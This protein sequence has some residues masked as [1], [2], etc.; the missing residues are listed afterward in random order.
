MSKI[1]FSQRIKF[2]AFLFFSLLLTSNA[3]ADGTRQVMPN[4]TNGTAIYIRTDASNSGP[5]IGAPESN[6]LYFTI[7]DATSENLY[8]G[9]QARIRNSY[10]GGNNPLLTNFYYRIFNAAGV[11]QTPPTLFTNSGTAAGYIPNYARA[12]AGPNIGGATPAGYNPIVFDPSANGDYYIELYSS[13]D[14]GATAV[15]TAPGGINF[16]PYFDFTVS[17]A[18]NNQ[19]DGRIWSRKW[20][21]ITYLVENADNNAGTP[22]VPNPSGNASFEGDFFAYTDDQVIVEVQFEPGFR[23]FGYQ[24]AM[25]RFGVVNDDDN[26]ANDFLLTR[27]SV[28]YGTGLAPSLD[29]GFQI[30]ITS[31]DQNVFVPSIEPDPVVA[32]E[33]RGCPGN[34]FIPITL[35]LAQDTAIILDFN[36]V[37]GYQENTEDVLIEVYENTPGLKLIPWDGNDGLGNPVTGGTTTIT[38]TSYI[39]RTNVPMD[40]AEL[41]INGLSISGVAPTVGNRRLFWD[42][43][44]ITVTNDGTGCNPTG[45]NALNNLTTVNP[46]F[47]RERLIDGIFG[48]AHA[49]SSSNPDDSVPAISQGGNNTNNVLCDDFGNTRIVNTWFYGATKTIPPSPIL[50]PSCDSDEDGLTDSADL[51]DDNDGILDTTEQAGLNPFGDEDGDGAADYYDSD[52]SGF[53]DAN[54]DGISDQFDID[55]DGLIN[56]FD[57]DADGDGC[58]DAVEGNGGFVTADLNPDGSINDTEDANGVPNAASG[59]QNDVSSQNAAVSGCDTDGDGVLNES[60]ICEGFDD[61][62]DSD[63]DSI[64]DGCDLDDDNDGI[65]DE[66]ECSETLNVNFTYN[67]TLSSNGNLVFTAMINGVEEILT[68]RQST[69]PT[70]YFG[71]TNTVEPSGVIITAG[72]TPS[73]QAQ[74]GDGAPGLDVFESAITFYSSIAI[75]RIQLP[76]LDDYDRDNNGTDPTDGIA[77]TISG[78][79]QINNGDMAS[80]DLNTGALISNN[81][82]GNASLNLSVG[83]SSAQELVSR[84]AIGSVLVRGTAG[85][86]TNGASATFIA[87]NPFTNASLL[88]EDLAQNGSR[89]NI[90]NTITSI[91]L[92]ATVLACP[93]TDNDGIPNQLDTDS[94]ADGC[95]DALEGGDNIDLTSVDVNGQLT[96]AVNT[97][98]GVPNNVDVNNGQSVGGSVDGVPSDAFGQCDSDGDGVI[99]AN[100]VCNGYDDNLNADGDAVPDGC[101]L[102]DDNDGILDSVECESLLSQGGFENVSGLNNGNNFPVDIS[103]WVLG[104][105]NDANVVQ[106]DGAGGFDYGSAGPFEDANPLTGAGTLQHYLDIANGSNDFYQSFTLT[107]TSKV[108]YSGYFSARDNLVGNGSIQ[109]VSGI[110][111]TG[112]VMDGTGILVIDSNGDSQNTPWLFIEREV[113]LPPGTYSYVVS[114]EEELNF[115]EARVLSCK[116]TDGDGFFDYQDIDSDNDGCND[117]VEAGHLDNDNNGEVDGTS[118]DA[119][120][121]V[122]GYSSAYTGTNVNV[123]TPTQV[124]VDASALLDQNVESGNPATF[125]IT[126]VS[127]TS[128]N[129]YT[130][131]APNTTP[132]YSVG[133][134]VSPGIN[135]QWYIGNPTSGGTAILASD[136]NYTGENS[137]TLNILDV[138][139]LNNTQYCL[140]ITHDNNNCINEINCV[141]LTVFINP[142]TQDDTI[143]GLTTNTAAVVDPFADNGNGIDTDPDGTLDASTVNIIT[144]GATDSDG[145]GD[146]D[147]L[148]VAGEGTW[149]VDNTTGAVTFTP[150]VGFTGDPTP[151][152]YTVEDNDGNVSNASTISLDYDAQ[153][154]ITQD[155]TITGLTTN[156]AAVVDPFADNGNGIDTDPD[157]TLDASTVNIITAGA[158]DSDGD[159]DNDTLVVAGEGTWTVDNTTGAVTFTPEVGFTGDPTP[160]AYTVED[161]DGN[162]SNAS[163]ISLDYDAQTPITQDD[164]ITG[165][166]TNTAAVVDPFADNGNGIDTDPDGTLDAST[167]NIITA[168]ATD[169]DGDGDND[170]LVVAGEGTWTVDNTTGAVT[171]TPEVGF[172]G[173]P[174]PIAYTVEDN[175]GNVSNASTISLDYD[176]QTPITQDDTITGLTTNTAAVVDPFAD[177]GN[178]IDTDPDGTL[179]ASTVNIITAGA[180]D[181]DGD[182][183]NDTLV[184]AG[185]GTWTV[186]NTT[187]AV[188][189]T[190]EVGF[191]GDPTPI[192]YTVEDN[193]GNV[194][195]ASTISLDYDAQT[196]ITQD[197]TIT[198][199]TTNTA[200]VVDPFADNGNGIDT[201]PDG[202]LDA[203]TVNIIT[204]GATDSDGDG[205]NDT[206]VVAGEGTWT[207]DNTTGAVTFTPEVGFTGDP[208]PIAYTVEDN[209]GNVSNA[210]TISLDY[211]AQTPITQ[212][213][214]ITGL[215]TN[216]AAVV[217]PFA[218]NGN[219]IDTDPDGTLDASTVNIITAGATDSDGDGDNDTLVVAGEGTWTVDNTTGAVTFTPEVGFTGDPTPIAYTVEDND[220]NVSNASTISLDYDAQTPITQD[221]TITGLTT[222]TA[223]V[224]DPFADNGNGIDTDPDGTLDAS[225]VNI[226]TAGATDSDG[227]GDNDTLVVAGEG[228]WTVDNTT[229]AVTFTPEVGFTGDPTPI[230]YTVEDNDGN[231]SNAST[232][233][234]DYDAQTPITQDDTITGLTTNTAAV[235]DPFADNGNGIDTDPDG[236]LDASTVNIITAGATD[237]DGD[238]DNDTLVVAG[239]GTWTVDNTTGAVTFTPEVGFTGDPTPIAYTVEDNDGNVSNAST[240]SLDYDAQTPITQ[241]DTITGLTTN[242]AAVVDPFADNGNGIDTDPDGTLDASTVNI[243]T[244]GATDSDGDGDNDTLVVAGEGTWTVDN[245]TGAVTFTP[246]VG[247]TGDPT[248]IAYTVEDNDGNVSNASTISL[249]YDAQTPITQDDTITGLTTNTAAVVDPFADNGNGIDTDPD[250]TLDA[251]TVNIIT[252]GATDSDGDGDNDTLV[253]AGEGTWTVDN[254][255]GAVTFT[256]EVGFTGDPT[257]IAYTVED[258]D[259]NVSNASTISL[260]YDA[261]TPITQDDTITGLTTNTAAVVD[262]FADNG[263]GIDTD[264]DGTLDA[265][266]VNIITAG[267]TDSDGDGDNDTLVVAGEGTWTVDNTTGAV[268]FTPEVGFTGDP[269][270]IAYTVEDNDG[271]VSNASTISLDYDAQTP[272]T[273]DDTITGLTTN[274]AAV[275]DPFAD[276]GNGIDTDPDGTLDASTVN[277]ITAGAT[278]SDGD[279]DNDTLVVAGEGTW[280]VDNTTGAVTFTPEVG[281]TG[282]PTP[283]AYTVEDNDGN[284]SNAS[285]ISL[286]YDAQTPITQDDTITGLTTNTAAVVDPFADNG[287]GIDTD[288][289]GTLDASTVNIITAGATDSDGDGDNDT[290]VVAGE[291]TWTVDNTTG[292]VTFTP[293]VGF[294]GDPTPIAYTVE[295]NDGNVSNASTISLDYDAQTPITQDDTITGLTTNTAAVVD[296]FA[297][298]GNG[299]DTDPDGTLDAST[300][301]IITAG[302]TD[303]DGDGDNDTLVVAGEGTWTVDNTTGAVTFTPEVGFTGDPTPIAYTVED[304]DGNVSNASTISLD[305]D[306][307]TPITQDDTITGLTTN[308]AAVVDPFAD[309]GNG[310]DT[311]PDGTLDASTV[312]I[313]T[314]GATDSDGD[315]DNDTL[316]V[317]GEGTWTVDNTTGAVTFTPEVGFTGDPTPIAYTVEDNDGNVS[318]AS[319]ISLDYD[320]QTPI[321]QDDTITGL[322]TNT[323][324]VVDPFAD[325]GN[326]I[327]TDPDGTLDASTVN[328]ITAGAT[329][330]DGDGDNDTLVVAGEGTWTVDNTTGAV[331]FTP[332]VGFTGD[333]T[334]IAYTVEDNDGNVSNA[335]TISLD[336]DA[337]TPIT[338]DDT[339]TGLTTNTAAVVDP[340]AD[341]G[342]GIDTDPDGTLD[343][344][345]VNIITAGATDSDGDGDNDTLVV[346]GEGT[347]TVD[348]TTGAV[349]FTPEVGFT[350]D[351]TPIAYT[352]EDNDGNVSNASTISL[353]YDAQ[354]PI[355]QDDTITGL[356]TNTAAVV[357]PFADNGNGIDTDPDGTLDASTVNIITAGAT[358]SDGDGDNDTLVVAGEG[359]WTVDNTTGAVTFTPEVGFTGDPTPIAYTVEDNDGNVSNASTISLDYDAQTPIT[360]D[361]TITGLTTNTAAVVDPFADNGN[362]I[363]TDPDGTLDASTVNIITA[364]ATDSDGDGDNDTLVVAGEGTWTVDNTTGAVTFTPEVGFTGDPTPIAYTVEDN[365]GNVSNASTISL[366]YDAQT[367]ITQDDTITGLTTNTA[368]VVD[369][370]ADN[371]NGI[372]T[373][374]DGTLDASTVNIITA[375]ATDSDGDGD[376]DTLVVAGEGTWTVDNTTGAVTFTPEVGFT[377]D[378]TP[379]AYTVEDN[380]GNVSN[381]STI[382]LDYDAQTPITQDDTITGLTTNTAAVVDPFAD[383]GNGIDTD[384]DGTL[385]ASTVNIITAGATDSDGDGDN[386]T[387]V[388]AGEGTWTVDNTT[389]AVTFTPEVGFTGDPTPIA[390]TVEDNDGNVSN[391]STISLD[392]D[393]QTPITQD[394]TITGLTTNTAAVVDPFADNGNGIDTDPDG[395]LDASTV[396]IIT[397][398][399]TDSDGDGDNDTLVVAGEGTWT[400][401]NTTG[402]VTFT[403]E[404]GFTGDPTPI[405]YTVE[406]NDGNVSNASTISLDYDAQ[407]PITQ[408]DTI[409]GLTT[410]TAAVVDPFADNGNGIDTDPDGTLD[411]STVNIITAGATDSDGDGDNDTLVV[412]GE[413]TWTVDNTTGAVTFTPEVGF[414]G[415]P[416]PI[417]YTVEDNDGNVSN[418]STISL[419]YDAQTPITQDDTITG[420][421]TNTAAVVDPFADNGN[422]IDTDPDG[423]LD[424]STVNIITAGATDS[425]GDGDNDTLVVAGE[426]TWTVDNT[427]GAVTFTPE[428]GFTGDPTPIAY[429][430]EDNDGNVSN[431]STISLDYDAQT[432]ITQD[433]TITGLTTN[434]AAVVD[435]FA[436]N[437]NGIDTDP[438]GTL[439]AST[440]NIITAGATDSDG[441]GDN[442][443]LVVAGEGT[444]TVDNTTGAVTFTPE[445]GFT[446]DPTPIAYTVEDNDGNV[447]NASTISLDYDAQTPIAINDTASTEPGISIVI[448]ILNNDNDPDGTIE[449]TTVDLDPLTPGQ[450]STITVPGEGTYTDNGDGTITFTPDPTFTGTTT[451]ISYTVEDNDGN[452]SNTAT[453]TVTVDTCPFPTDSDGD[454]LTDCEETTG[455]D[456]PNT[457]LVPTGPSDPNDPCDPIGLDATDTDGDGLTDCEETTGNDDPNTP[458]VPTGPS[459]PND[460]CDPIG[461]DATDTDGDGLTDCE[462]TTGNDDPNTPLVPTGP[463]DPNDPCDPIGLDATDTDGDG[464]TDCEETTGND[465]PNT[466]LVP[467]GPSDPNDPCDPIGLNATDTDGD[468]LTD[469]EE[470]TGNDDPNTP[471]VPTGPSDPNDPCDPIGLDATDTDGD[472]LTDCEETTGN[473][474]PNTPLVPTGPSDPNDPCDPIGLDATD[475]DGDGLTD[476][477]ETTGNDDP[478]TPLVPTGPSDPNDPCD[479]IGLDATDTDG[480][481]LT[482]CEE[483]TG[484]DDPNTPLV[485]TGPSD[486]NDPCDPIGLDATDTDGDGLTDCEETT[487]NDDP[488]TPLVPT[489]PSDPNDPCDPNT[490]AGG[491]TPIAVDDSSSTQPNTPVVIDITDNDSDPNGTIED[492]TV[493]LDPLTPGQQS[494]ITV[495]GEGTYTD[496]GDGTITFTPDPTFT[497]TTTPI[498]YT[499]EDNDGNVS[500]TATITVTVDTCPFPTDSDGDG[501]TDCEETT[502]NDDPNTPLVPT[503][504]SD[505]N[506]PCDPIG[507]D[508]TDTDGDGL[509]DCEETTGNDDPNTPLVP[510]GP[511]DPND[512]C[513]PIGLN[514]TDTDGDGLTDCEE[515]TGNDDPNTPLVPTGPSDP[516]DPCDPIG[517]DATDTD[518]DGLTDCEETTGNDDPNTPLVPTGPSDPNDP[519]DPIGLDAT[520]TDGDGLTDCEETTG[521]DDPNTPLVPTGPSDPNDPCDPIGLDATDTDGDGL[522]DCEET[523]GND[524]PNTPLVPTGPSDPNDPCD[525]IGLDATDTDGDG[526]T[527]CEE[528]T[529]NDDPNTPLVPTGPSDPNDPCDPI[530]LDATDTDGDGLTDCEETTGNDDP[531]TPLVPTGPSDPND[532]CDPIGLN[533][534][535]TDGDGLT[536]C[537][538]TTGNDDPNTPLVP[539]GPSDPND[540]CDPIGLDA[541]DTDGDGL[542]DCEETTGN[543]DPNTPLVPTG[544]SDPNDP[545]DP[546]G[547][548]ATD[549]DGDGLT[550][551]EE[552]TG[553]DDPNTP[554]VPTGPSDP[555][556]PCDP[557]GLDATDTD[558]DGLTDCEE[559]TG[560]DDPNTPLV[561]TGPS[562]PND[563]CD[564]IGLDATDTD[565]DG[566]TDCEETTGNDDPNTPLVPTGPSDPNDPCDPIGLNATDTDGD[567]LTDCEETTGNDD[568][569]TPLVPTGPSDPNDP[570]D[571][572]GLDATDTDGDG[573][574]DCEETTGNDDPN[575]PLVPTG[576]SDPNDPCDPIGLDATDTDGDGL[577][578]CEETTGNDD[579][580]TPLV[581]TGPSDPNDPCDPIGLDA[582]DTD[583]DGLTD[584]E[585]TTGNDDP[586]T[587]LVPTGPSDPNDPC[588]P[589]GLDA[590][591]TDGDGLTDCEETTGNDDPNTPLVP[592]GPSDPNDPC[593][594][595]TGAGGC[596][597]IAVD[598]SSST[599]P[600]TPVVIDI[601]DNDSDPNGTIEDTT[602]DLDPLTPGQQ[603]T[604]TVPGEGTYT[605]NGDGT[606]TFTP[607]PTFTGTTTPIS[608]TVEDN[609][610]NVSNTATITVTVDTCPFPTDSDGDGL[611]DCEETTGNDDPNT[612]LVPTG[613][614]D[615]N[616]P[617]DPIGLD[618]TDTDGDGLTDCEETTGNDD[619]NTPL[620][621]TGPSDP[622]DP[623]D[624][625]GLDATDT[626]GDGLTDCEETTGNDDPNTPLVPTGPSDPNDPC[627]PIGLDATDTD[628]DGLTDCEE[629]TGN[630]DPNTPLV[631]TGPSDPND[632]CDP[633]GLDATDTDGDGLTDC[634]ETTGN[635]DPNTPLVPTGPSDPNDPCDPNTGAGGCTPIAVDD[636]SSTQPNTPVVI[637]ITD[638]DSDPNGTIE[639]TTVDLDPL[640]PGQQSTITVPGEGTYTDNGDG[641]I[642][643]TPDPTF[644]G[645]TTPISYTVEDNDGNVSNT[646]TITVTVDTCPFPTDSDGDGLTDCEETTGNDD[647]NTPLV[648][649]GPSDPNDPCDPIGL[650]ATDTDGDGLTDCEETTGN[651]DPN[652]PLVPTGP[653]DPNDPCDPIG[654]DATDTD[655]D[656]LTDC[657]ETT[658]N[659]DPNTPLVPTGP[660][661]PN[662]PCD[663]IGLNATDTD[664]DGLTDCEETTGNDDPNTPLVPTG[665]S[666]PNDPCDPIGLDATDTD[667]DGLTDCEETTGND[668]PNTPLVPTGPSDPNDPCDPIGLDATDSDGDGLTDCEETTGIDDPNTPLVPTGPSDP[669]DPCDPN[670]GAGGCTPIAVDDSVVNATSGSPVSVDV[671]SNDSDANGTI[672]PT[673]VNLTDP[674]AFDADG[675]GY[676]DTLVVP[677]EG[678]WVVDPTT[679]IITFI[680]ESGFTDDPTPIGYTV[681]DNDGNVSNEATVSIDYATQNPIAEDDDS[682]LN[683]FGSI[684]II[685]LVA[686][687]GNGPDVDSDGTLD[688]STINITTNGATD[689]DGDGFNDTLV[690]PGEGTWTIDNLGILTFTPED[691]FNDNPTPINYTI[692]DNDGNVS[693]QA[694]I[695]ITYEP[696]GDPDGDGV[697]S[698]VEILEGT[699]S[700]NPCDYNPDSV[701]EIQSEPWLSSDCDGDGYL[702]E[703][704]INDGTNPLDACDFNYLNEADVAQSGDWFDADCD[705]DNVPNGVEFPYG[706]TD[707]DGIPDWLDPDDDGDGIDTVN[708]DYGDT[709]ISDGSV[710]STGDNNPTNDDTDGDGIPDYLD[711]DDDND[712]ILTEDEYPDSNGNGIGFGDDAVDSDGDGLPDYLGVNNANPSE[713][714]LEVFNAVTPNGD[715]DN[716]VFVI[717]NIELYPDNTVTIYNRWGVIVYQTSGYG[718]SGNFFNGVSNGRATIE[719]DKQLPVGTYF[720]II[721]YNNGNE[722]K[723]KAGYLY[724]QR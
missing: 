57:T 517:L 45:S 592:T 584:C 397:A 589:I 698:S 242:T 185:E 452:V 350:G 442:D 564:P 573:L 659:D 201:D 554:L 146:N 629:T 109:I 480:D 25:N 34:Y 663:P 116:D 638:N 594:P 458:L 453:I 606:I 381:A 392:Y 546:I 472:G 493:D 558:G 17:D 27:G 627:D 195:N 237:S 539:T 654:L 108:T 235:V 344:S 505:P 168:G 499:V 21:F 671:T 281:F 405:A 64:P 107:T 603:S 69:N 429:T 568:P 282:D 208:T 703:T 61:S 94:D 396:N 632:P 179:D 297:D 175:D 623:C 193:D 299:I 319:T 385:D 431:A 470:T 679:G 547:L 151:I 626:D 651:D 618:A 8:F 267:A 277:I 607:D 708:E 232:I 610:G 524:D 19:V 24:L 486:P 415:D 197:D 96:G 62:V 128:T 6:R 54:G 74:D 346:A 387:L 677:G 246:E 621:P 170:T 191:T 409:T 481:G 48:P 53:V 217:D 338:Q 530:G 41:N 596:T 325:N 697:L 630:D 655:G 701:T 581:P 475:T 616:D 134:D 104:T 635:D 571:P 510:T 333:P 430:V 490:G 221:D 308:T 706:D 46:A 270:P 401:D 433:D 647:P 373:D 335:S 209:D 538:E 238:G 509:T 105:G 141:T 247:F 315:G 7:A 206:L 678:T 234:L 450:Q 293:E 3:F 445:V 260:D 549:T 142:I 482:D 374:P 44:N 529:G 709:D 115:D 446:G 537:E 570:C 382:S 167:V 272:I 468:G 425:D 460:P 26:P 377:G 421:T 360:Q 422:G 473:D 268:T 52:Y 177:N 65:L 721:E 39:G 127:A 483:T 484:N 125:T 176:A 264:P 255:T 318:N 713:D 556:D 252:A 634:E 266:T 541:T 271:N 248:P 354:T 28:S 557:I 593:D 694:T 56:Q 196:P 326:G 290:L 257:P 602:V 691:G 503:G 207:V 384:P 219:G 513:D 454:G 689:S 455:I 646:A 265:S 438:D 400:V 129:T 566:L 643:F 180:T 358:D 552:T 22:N 676:N 132:D 278:D 13:N 122:V 601:T 307:Q 599:Q 428:V 650:D 140:L 369:P 642:T 685:D 309:N 133:T 359:T 625:I 276:N 449:D 226:I 117:A 55:G 693:N 162:V 461:L 563:P 688:L 227:D 178:G 574:T 658:G 73:I 399:A 79:W 440:V 379:I 410:N 553:N 33:I 75:D 506:D 203:S 526:L 292:A 171:F 1:T 674:S 469:C 12:V 386:D 254:T 37:A 451:P 220:G 158:T 205:D 587:P 551:C 67:E 370:F 519:C 181:S 313:I 161:N 485:P 528:T 371:G 136:S 280:T 562:D 334:P 436:D 320:A 336:Y 565:G 496:N 145:D 585:E 716:D 49:W 218:D 332:E 225:T 504:P 631:P 95:P 303:S 258:N 113:I 641:T 448:P 420:L 724:I 542:T 361:D 285:T 59:G 305:Y 283:I 311:D 160:I 194:S 89:E 383:N 155:D 684:V 686:D 77:F 583:G 130:G 692:Q 241:D 639:D 661:D 82:A 617:C 598:D 705:N 569:N 184:V 495:P 16:L 30:F 523:T 339:I 50:I 345:T 343:A 412:A 463:S 516:N 190:P 150:E 624:P 47:S 488:N 364:G 58:F 403:P 35:I 707:N 665:P 149:T 42:D 253:V 378:P 391:A 423:T 398:G 349:T 532:P 514:A 413:G 633:I 673:T 239:E 613:P 87:N 432:P 494:T 80:Y 467:T 388:V 70:H 578:D 306:A 363:D 223:A 269:T 527:D 478:N 590:T 608:Y 251:S 331:T 559:T 579:P 9:V 407:T 348:N 500:N 32:D 295:D 395:T 548:D 670:T 156:T 502:G 465:D 408:D 456:D 367:P 459:D 390:Y 521:N 131:T 324:A 36:G 640:T 327:D 4:A 534:T 20:S 100:D 11:A 287:N 649:T 317:A 657:E 489:G 123:T 675:D 263:N 98:T 575:T 411:A 357:D 213:D 314:A 144:A 614:S 231:V 106:V 159:G 88:F 92:N 474:D 417:A 718:Q 586:N 14:G 356:T 114:M 700:N 404:V 215:T 228:T 604:I 479:P 284:V 341:N 664:G 200:A 660:S 628:G 507:L 492:T 434:T 111:T 279:G 337:Q 375:G 229:G 419:D 222:N 244:A 402:A 124:V 389:G 101:D 289:D 439:D 567:G 51:D 597:P 615:P 645:T 511:S 543:D 426:G 393:A 471:L 68:I 577:T 321:T 687:N 23:P 680:P 380:D 212:D 351:P 286:D 600:N 110:G 595:N 662:D 302:A 230:A 316:V 540:P 174:T 152:A 322:T 699:D 555:N 291:G 274:T 362:G 199:L 66:N 580:N 690:V 582:T 368:A 60:D 666:D 720:Y 644:T 148:V 163:T 214:T 296:P 498:S 437:G 648:P 202:T 135:Y 561:P 84:G 723:S 672:D 466:P 342:N 355:T 441:D 372:D 518:G 310:I 443:T 294:T 99:D 536:D 535:D 261:Q 497:G 103:P 712:G 233:S 572:I 414:T 29:N 427:T 288:P 147:T 719:A 154:P 424:A 143:T 172:T 83:G 710:D 508:A 112:T 515:T 525:P 491:C 164:T 243:I 330:S 695:T 722:T 717:R 312:N 352:V 366:D 457:P 166:T 262:P 298:N 464:L 704:E 188:T 118:Y 636:S 620:V 198:G 668:D 97:T 81:Q 304:N 119:N 153:T 609:D 711:T 531:N 323:A 667:G 653:S 121:Q 256:P 300:V 702:N 612:P 545:C 462:E 347:W 683:P 550:D 63:G 576:P 18:A 444:W 71:S 588:D 340:F 477:E 656:G 102:D 418:A 90:I 714:D 165:L 78:T 183:D 682:L 447:S 522:T 137:Q 715:G 394:D 560:N 224:V 169:S 192:A 245:T 173:D 204:A 611:T 10:Q 476:C 406:D 76:T 416:T 512:P 240:I 211:D 236:T 353:D 544:P 72:N 189:F 605:D 15:N 2:V 187:G 376:N 31:P 210:S 126:S 275:V 216:T 652:T 86:E 591:D 520:D 619:P 157:G 5:Y 681:E 669:N 533:A 186:D 85:G 93:D 328:I 637:D 435:P 43:R 365:D 329:D 501:L 301:N 182:G 38:V 622:N 259:G 120:G 40:D 250:G 139:G 696:D 138:T 249:D 273:Q 91:V 487:G